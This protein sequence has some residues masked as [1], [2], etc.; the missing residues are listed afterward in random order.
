M[1]D[2]PQPAEAQTVPDAGK[3]AGTSIGVHPEQ[4]SGASD[5]Q[6]TATTSTGAQVQQVW[7]FK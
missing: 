4:P 3:P 2:S 6:K 1:F 7:H 5:L